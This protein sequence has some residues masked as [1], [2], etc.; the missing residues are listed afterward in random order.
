VLIATVAPG[1]SWSL[2]AL[3]TII[4]QTLTLAQIRAVGPENQPWG[5]SLPAIFLP[6]RVAVSLVGDDEA[7]GGG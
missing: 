3:R 7:E 5:H 4:N 2:E 6:D 1:E